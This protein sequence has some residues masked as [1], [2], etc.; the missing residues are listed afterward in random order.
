[1]CHCAPVLRIHSTASST[2]RVGVGCTQDAHRKYSPIV[3]PA[4]RLFAGR[5]QVWRDLPGVETRPNPSRW[6][7]AETERPAACTS[8]LFA[9]PRGAQLMHCLPLLSAVQTKNSASPAMT[10]SPTNMPLHT[11]Q[12]RNGRTRLLPTLR[13]GDR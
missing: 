5:L 9:L 3:T 7:R 8:R 1:M 10:S 4:I 6:K 12:R 2:Q 13:T 11:D